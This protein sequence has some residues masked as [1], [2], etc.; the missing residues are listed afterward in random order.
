MDFFWA[1]HSASEERLLS[2]SD[3]L[4]NYHLGESCRLRFI[5]DNQRRRSRCCHPTSRRLR[6]VRNTS[7]PRLPVGEGGQP[8]TGR[9]PVLPCELKG[10]TRDASMCFHFEETNKSVRSPQAFHLLKRICLFFFF[11]SQLVFEKIYH[12]WTYM[13]YVFPRG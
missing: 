8:E 10:K 3:C 9:E 2:P 4:N 12:Y 5:S 7:L 13:F 1:I 6:Q 11:F